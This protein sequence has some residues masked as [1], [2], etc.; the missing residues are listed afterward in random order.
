MK[1]EPVSNFTDAL[2][3][4]V[5]NECKEIK[6]ARLSLCDLIGDFHE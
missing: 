3:G 4:A 5:T 1:M 2:S 6:A